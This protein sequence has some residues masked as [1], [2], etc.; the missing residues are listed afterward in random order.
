[1]MNI[2]ESLLLIIA[3]FTPDLSCE[4][5][6]E[7]LFLAVHSDVDLTALLSEGRGERSV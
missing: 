3:K 1:M 6:G 5:L 2:Q 7:L 4:L